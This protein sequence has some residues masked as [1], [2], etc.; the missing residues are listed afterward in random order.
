[1]ALLLR[2][3]KIVTCDDGLV[4]H[5]VVVC[6]FNFVTVTLNIVY[7]TKQAP[8]FYVVVYIYLSRYMIDGSYFFFKGAM[9]IRVTCKD[10]VRLRFAN[11]PLVM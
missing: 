7:F 2:V 6:G 8:P 1:V 3:E 9:K 10:C 11:N 5:A 4:S